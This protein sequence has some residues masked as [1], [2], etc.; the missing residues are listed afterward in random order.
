MNKEE[1][2]LLIEEALDQLAE[3]GILEKKIKPETGKCY[4]KMTELGYRLS[5]R[6]IEEFIRH[7]GKPN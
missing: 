4:Y 3:Y 2:R 6:E 7:K 1:E 5:D